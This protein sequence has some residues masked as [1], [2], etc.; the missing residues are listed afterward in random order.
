MAGRECV[1]LPTWPLRWQLM[2]ENGN[3]TAKQRAAV[4]ALVTSRTVREAEQA[5]GV[6]TSTMHRWRKQS[7]FSEAVREAERELYRD[8]LRLLLA[9]Q[10]D[11]LKRIVKLRDEGDGDPVRLRA[12]A[13]LERALAR[14]FEG[15]TL[16]EIEERI[17]ALEARE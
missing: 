15:L 8:G 4:R 10:A 9:D 2:A 16:E 12:A 11:N 7:A 14:R 6:S 13:T 1:N 5:A 3:L 17:A